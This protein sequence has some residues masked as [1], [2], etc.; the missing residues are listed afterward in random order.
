MTEVLRIKV[1]SGIIAH[2]GFSDPFH[3]GSFHEFESSIHVATRRQIT[4]LLALSPLD[5]MTS[6]PVG[7][8]VA[9]IAHQTPMKYVRKSRGYK[10]LMTLRYFGIYCEYGNKRAFIKLVLLRSLLLQRTA[11]FDDP[12]VV[13][14]TWHIKNAWILFEYSLE[15]SKTDFIKIMSIL[16]LSF[17]NERCACKINCPSAQR[18]DMIV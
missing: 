7:R 4:E 14:N 17:F 1:N 9:G 11:V 13:K 18:F 6:F 2:P 15:N 12:D 8:R 3:L 5:N 10:F 16:C